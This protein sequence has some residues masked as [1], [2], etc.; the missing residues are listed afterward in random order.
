MLPHPSQEQSNAGTLPSARSAVMPAH[1]PQ[2]H[3][4]AGSPPS[5]R[6]TVMLAHPL[7]S[8]II[9]INLFLMLFVNPHNQA[10]L[11][12]VLTVLPDNFASLYV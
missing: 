2:E 8:S 7:E 4:N 9:I 1:P 6:S 5:A 10:G 12:F 11:S 3:S